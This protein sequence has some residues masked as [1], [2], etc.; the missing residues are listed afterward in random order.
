MLGTLERACPAPETADP[1]SS[2]ALLRTLL[3]LNAV[4]LRRT[5]DLRGYTGDSLA[6]LTD[7]RRAYGYRHVERFLST[8]AHVGGAE[9]LTD[10]LATWTAMLWRSRLR[11]ADAP[12]PTFYIDGHRKPVYADGLIPRAAWS[13]DGARSSAAARYSCCTTPMATRCWSRPTAATRT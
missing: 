9:P 10:A 6:L 4:G 13:G 8:L 12:L 1:R 7:R 11:T 2:S 3:F 5:W